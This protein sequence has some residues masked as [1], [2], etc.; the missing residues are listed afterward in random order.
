MSKLSADLQQSEGERIGVIEARAPFDLAS[1]AHP[2]SRDAA[3]LLRPLRAIILVTTH[4]AVADGWSIGVMAREMGQIY[5]SLRN[6]EPV[7]LEPLA[8]QYA[9][10]SLWQLE[11]LRVRGTAAE[12]EYWSKQ[13]AGVKPFKVVPDRP[14][15]AMPTTSGA[16][17]SKVLPRE[18]TNEA[19]A[20]TAQRGATL[21]SAALGAL[22]A[23]LS[24]YTGEREIVVGT[25]VSDRDQVELEPM[26]GQF[27]NSLILRND[28][29]GDPSFNELIDRIRNTSM[30]ALKE[31]RHIP[32][33]QLLRHG[34]IRARQRQYRA[35]LGQFHLPKN[36][37]REH[38]LL[39]F[40]AHRHAVA[41]G[42]GHL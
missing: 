20:L 18:L 22:C 42:C 16:I 9:D 29:H 13:L 7:A 10:Y 38:R 3:A 5:E 35:D 19:Q 37:H 41:A 23:M 17:A 40:R 32:I 31:H 27:V 30:Q 11:W 14:R 34:Q 1:R 21:F 8:I 12:T 2:D 26:I 33:E 6:N 36:I 15:P 39:R 28:V 25:Q 24:R 4:Q